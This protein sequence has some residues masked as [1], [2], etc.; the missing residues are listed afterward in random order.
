MRIGKRL[1][2]LMMF[3]FVAFL[4]GLLAAGLIVPV[5]G[6]ATATGTTMVQSL[7]NLPT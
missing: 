3:I 1:Y 6:M 7:D 5:A 4:G 2:S